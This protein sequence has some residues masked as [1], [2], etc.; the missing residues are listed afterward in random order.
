MFNKQNLSLSKR[1]KLSISKSNYTPKYN[2]WLTKYT[3]DN[4]GV[5]RKQYGEFLASFIKGEKN[6]FVLN[7]NGKWGTGKTQFLRRLYTHFY[8]DNH[9]VIYIDAWESDFTNDPLLVV[10]SELL[11]QLSTMLPVNGNDLDE[12]KELLGKEF[13]SS[14]ITAGSFIGKQLMDDGATGREIVKIFMD[15]TPKDLLDSIKSGYS[16]QVE[17]IKQV[18]QQL[19]FIAEALMEN[20]R[21]LPVIVLIDELDRCRPSYSI[22]MLE[23]IKHFFDT[24]HFVFVVATDTEQLQ[25][26]IKAVYGEQFDSNAYLRR[27]FDRKAELNSPDI[28]QFL[29]QY[30]FDTHNNIQLYPEVS[31]VL[32]GEKT[33]IFHL[34]LIVQAYELQLRDLDQLIAKYKSCMR[35]IAA[36]SEHQHSVNVFTL[37][38]AIVEFETDLETLNQR[39]NNNPLS[40]WNKKDFIISQ[41]DEEV[42]TKFSEYYQL[43]M[44]CSVKHSLTKTQATFRSS[45]GPVYAHN[46]PKYDYSREQYSHLIKSTFDAI[47]NALPPGSQ[48]RNSKAWMWEK[49]RNLVKLA[50]TIK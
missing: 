5:G 38:V 24:K 18:R 29:K 48:H 27:F 23:V 1:P 40:E 2:E 22:E 37:L 8:H 39:Q 20:K 41:N 46:H 50:S 19:E 6:G 17:A 21:T 30:T 25:N 28:P 47:T 31:H 26:S 43:N 35:A 34:L 49:Y 13:K 36:D 3:F 10:A 9:P 45:T 16:D 12:L 42:K 44:N 32:H 4:C 14:L 33:E 15:K 7:L 11:N